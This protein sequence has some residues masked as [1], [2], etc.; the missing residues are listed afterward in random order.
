MRYISAVQVDGALDYPRLIARLREAFVAPCNAPLRHRHS[1]VQPS[2]TE[3]TVLIKPAWRDGTHGPIAVKIVNVFPDNLAL[4]LSS[5]QGLVAVFD[6]RTGVPLGVIEGQALT[7]RRTAAAS[8]L[9]AGYLA[10]E[11]ARTLLVVGTGMLAPALAEAHAM[12]RPIRQTLVWGRDAGK[13]A[14]LAARLSAAGQ[15]AE[16]AEDLARAV[17]SAD[18]ITC[19]T[20]AREPLIRG[21]WLSAGTHVDL[22]GSYRPDMREA[23]DDVLRRGRIFVDTRLGALTETGDLVD[24]LARGVITEADIQAELSEL[25]GGTARGRLGP[26]EITVFKSVG[27][28]LEDLAA[29]ELAL[30]GAAR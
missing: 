12:V 8:A 29:A 28:A 24:P 30:E 6:G 3:A 23:D 7:V 16:P 27:T 20:L 18:V 11:H 13:A 14:A 1:I 2:G 19:A 10:P 4:G 21:D 25:C 26:A 5:I 15:P 22:V 9:A 17:T